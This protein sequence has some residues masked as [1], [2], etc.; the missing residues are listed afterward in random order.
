MLDVEVTTAAGGCAEL[1][2]EEVANVAGVVVAE[3]D[4]SIGVLG[5]RDSFT[6]KVTETSEYVAVVSDPDVAGGS[7]FTTAV[8][9]NPPGGTVLCSPRAPAMA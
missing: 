3:L 7:S 2:D 4:R 8:A 5:R 1:V 9:Q 6:A